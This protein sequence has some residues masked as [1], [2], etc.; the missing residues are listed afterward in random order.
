ML[1]AE[2]YPDRRGALQKV[3]HFAG[4][5]TNVLRRWWKGTRNPPPTKLVTQKKGE[6]GDRLEEIVH[7]ILDLLPDALE[8]AETRELIT[9]LG[10][11]VDKWQLVRG[12]P[13]ERIEN[14]DGLTDDER[15]ERIAAILDAARARRDRPTHL[16]E[17]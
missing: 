13:T 2:G 15:A 9:G 6:I 10:V 8:V 1:E 11:T 4:I 16:V 7:L 3:A 5:H 12:Q 14:A 17:G